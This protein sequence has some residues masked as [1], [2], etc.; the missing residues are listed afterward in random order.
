MAEPTSSPAHLLVRVHLPRYWWQWALLSLLGF[1]LV[2]AAS[3]FFFLR[4]YQ[5]KVYPGVSV[6]DIVVSGLSKGAA[7]E[8]LELAAPL[9]PTYTVEVA[10]DDIVVSS[11]SAELGLHYEY[12]KTIDEAF[13]IGRTGT[14]WDR[15]KAVVGGSFQPV[16]LTTPLAYDSDRVS[17]LMTA[18]VKRVDTPY[19]EP[20]ARL[21]S[22]GIPTSIQVVQGVVGRAVD[23]TLLYDLLVTS[24]PPAQ[25]SI[26]AP[27][28]SVGA[29]LSEPQI[30]EFSNRAKAFAGKKGTF[31]GERLTVR[32][33]DQELV[34]LLN[35]PTGI[36]EPRTNDLLHKWG[37]LVNRPAQDP[38]F[39]YDKDTLKVIKFKPPV[40]GLALDQ[41]TTR[42]QLSE[43]VYTIDQQASQAPLTP[44][45]AA[46]DSATPQ[47]LFEES[48]AVTTTQPQKSLASTND[49]GIKEL[50]GFG[51]SEYAHSIPSRIHNV[52]HA[53]SR[54]LPYIVKPG[55]EFSFNKALGDVSRATGYQPAYVISGGQTVL[56]DGGG[57]CQVSTTL[58]R[59]VLNAGL[60]VTKRKA[61]SYR[62]SYYELDSKPGVDAT[63]YSGE[64]D[65]RFVNDTGHHVLIF[66]ETDS[67]RLYMKME[68][69]GTS[70]GRTTEITDHITYDFRSAPAPVYIPDPT[71]RPG[72]L[73]QIDWAAS[74][75]K[76]SFKNI[77]KDKDGKLIRE[78]SYFSNYQPWSAKY[79]RGI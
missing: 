77:V 78:E 13:A 42:R 48:L 1:G 61:H 4:A 69:Y 22:A 7:F 11:S 57:V 73:K 19:Q 63:V 66:G 79:L 65:L 33:S 31:K 62:V 17:E 68:L 75:I 71:L 74:G 53:T 72:Q 21:A 34:E 54:L 29:E 46:T 3:V 41:E 35:Y 9:P 10:V 26:A 70:D 2:A 51:E 12:Q 58:F 5:G 20:K 56:G 49:L 76:A 16:K 44:S 15:V 47:T 6:N 28:A 59:S 45:P 64:V 52:S 8:R 55:E 30:T 37:E 27:V 38:E 24:T 25:H 32:L 36:S 60:P 43:I 67:D 14:W 39:E 40:T 23:T 18:L 50:I